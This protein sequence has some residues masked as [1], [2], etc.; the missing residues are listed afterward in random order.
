MTDRRA[1]AAYSTHYWVCPF[2]YTRDPAIL[3]SGQRGAAK[4]SP[5]VLHKKTNETSFILSGDLGSN[6][7]KR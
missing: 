6:T 7:E 1:D 2:H 4:P 3:Y 5:S